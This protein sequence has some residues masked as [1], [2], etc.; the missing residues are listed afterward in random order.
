MTQIKPCPFCGAVPIIRRVGNDD[1]MRRSTVI[2]C[3][4]CES[5]GKTV[6]ARHAPHEYCDEKAIEAWNRRHVEE[7]TK[8]ADEQWM[9]RIGD[10]V[11]ASPSFLQRYGEWEG[12]KLFV[13]GLNFDRTS[14]INVTVC[15]QWPP[16]PGTTDGFYIY[17]PHSPDD[18]MPSTHSKEGE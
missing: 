5:Q 14:G 6:A 7:P 18:L 12:V 16:E 11:V 2:F 10:A 13:C 4:S 15:E 17:L 9:P 3:H 1:T 8:A